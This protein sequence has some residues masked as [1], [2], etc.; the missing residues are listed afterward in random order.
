MIFEESTCAV[1]KKLNNFTKYVRRQ[2]IARFLAQIEVFK[3]Q[4]PVKGSIV[5]CG[6]S[7]GGGVM[8]WAKLSSILEPYNHHRKVIGFDTFKG[9]PR[10]SAIDVL[11]TPDVKEGML[12][13]AYD[14]YDELN[15]C[16]KEYDVPESHTKN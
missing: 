15:R 8:A 13:E 3:M 9:F 2:K 12:S 7:H 14:I 6:V 1:E 16:I 4:L 11:N 10:V 5:E